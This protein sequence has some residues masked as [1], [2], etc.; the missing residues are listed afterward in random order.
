M[1]WNV[2]IALR[3]VQDRFAI[4]LENVSIPDLM[5]VLRQ[6][7]LFPPAEKMNKPHKYPVVIP[8]IVLKAIFTGQIADKP[9]SHLGEIQVTET[10]ID[11][12]EQCVGLGDVWPALRL[13]LTCGFVGCC[14]TSKN[15]HAKK[16]YEETGHPLMRSI[17]LNERWVWCHEDN[18]FFEGRVLDRYG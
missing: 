9:C 2:E 1:E 16:H 13:C 18:A 12:C 3:P 15:K 7:E 6:F 10:T 11:Y 8:D 17:R 4:S 14:D 5:N